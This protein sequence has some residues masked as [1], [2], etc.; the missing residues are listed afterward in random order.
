M[1]KLIQY[2]QSNP[3]EVIAIIEGKASPIG[4]LNAKEL[5][6]VIRSVMQDKSSAMMRYWG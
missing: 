3:L 1:N 4:N 2:L 6:E 5:V